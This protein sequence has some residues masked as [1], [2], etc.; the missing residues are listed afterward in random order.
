MSYLQCIITFCYCIFTLYILFTRVSVCYDVVM[1]LCSFCVY[2]FYLTPHYKIE[3]DE[4]STAWHNPGN[5]TNGHAMNI[6][7]R[8]KV[9]RWRCSIGGGGGGGV[10]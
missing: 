2:I 9:D 3:D 10:P 5:C 7:L 1:L 4:T 6:D 8:D